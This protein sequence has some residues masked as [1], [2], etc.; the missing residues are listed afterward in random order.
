MASIL[1]NIVPVLNSTNGVLWSE[2]IDIFVMSEGRRQVFTKARPTIP[3]PT[4][5]NNGNVNNQDDIDKATTTQ[6]DWDYNNE[7]VMGYIHL[8]IFSDVA[9]LVKGKSSMKEM[10][11]S[12]KEGHSHQTLANAYVE[13]KGILDTRLPED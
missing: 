3:S 7:C 8:C 2:S 5:D 13:F 1:L 4:H 10:W 12:L 6:E 9:Q 11:D